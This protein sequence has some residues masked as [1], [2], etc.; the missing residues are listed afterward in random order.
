MIVRASIAASLLT[1]LSGAAL[2][3]DNEK[4]TE[5]QRRRRT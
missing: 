4:L 5:F 1:L 2:G 3:Q